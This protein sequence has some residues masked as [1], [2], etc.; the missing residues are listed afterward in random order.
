MVILFG[1][2]LNVFKRDKGRAGMKKTRL[3]I[4]NSEVKK[5]VQGFSVKIDIVDISISREVI[6]V[7]L[8]PYSQYT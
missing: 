2:Y 4:K 5:L 3:I 7:E 6:E 8:I 1:N